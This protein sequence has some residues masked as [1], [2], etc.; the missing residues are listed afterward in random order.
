MLY[1]LQK[2]YLSNELFIRVPPEIAGERL[3]NLKDSHMDVV[4]VAQID[5]MLPTKKC[6]R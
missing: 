3:R 1:D 4:F 2:S 5:A 6:C